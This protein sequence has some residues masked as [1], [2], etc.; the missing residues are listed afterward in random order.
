[1]TPKLSVILAV[2]NSAR[3]LQS[4]I[5]SL[6]ANLQ[7]LP[8]ED[9]EILV[10]YRDS[11]DATLQI[12]SNYP[13]YKVISESRG[14]VPVAHNIGVENAVGRF[15]VFLNSDDEL[16][17][18]YLTTMLR[19]V[20]SRDSDYHVV[21]STIHFIDVNGHVLYVRYPAPYIGFIQKYYSIVMHPN[22]IYPMS[23]LKKHPF[24]V[25]PG[26]PPT[27]REQVYELM[28]DACW[29]RTTR[30]WYR[31][32]IWGTSTSIRRAAS[33]P[34]PSLPVRLLCLLGR[35]YVQ[36]FET[37]KL[38]RLFSRRFG[39]ESYWRDPAR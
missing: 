19:L 20:E 32:R 28:R 16:G 10:P 24:R 25:L 2:Y 22:A 30:V 34:R 23:L 18:G 4:C 8:Q 5:D 1:M 27:D 12:L 13:R 35:F 39:A 33:L 15:G 36:S 37:N 6:E 26:T 3:T 11:Q 9:V 38:Q 21:Y 17:P 29:I 7:E 31:F 14:G